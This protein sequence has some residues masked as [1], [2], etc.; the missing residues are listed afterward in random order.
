MELLYH[1]KTINQNYFGIF[2]KLGG[3]INLWFCSTI[4]SFSHLHEQ[5]TKILTTDN[6]ATIPAI[7]FIISS[8]SF[9]LNGAKKSPHSVCI[10]AI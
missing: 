3:T 1:K 2:P 9:Q 7:F 4:G 8:L 10:T 5:P 6:N